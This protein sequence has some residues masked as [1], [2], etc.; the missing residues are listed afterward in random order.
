MRA[1]WPIISRNTK[2]YVFKYM[3]LEDRWQAQYGLDLH[4]DGKW[5]DLPKTGEIPLS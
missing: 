4:L 3:P 1:G 2:V 5:K